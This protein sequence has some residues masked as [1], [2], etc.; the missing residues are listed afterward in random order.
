MTLQ[1]TG[2]AEEAALYL[3]ADYDAHIKLP[4]YSFTLHFAPSSAR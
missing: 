2:T 4:G 1:H 3:A